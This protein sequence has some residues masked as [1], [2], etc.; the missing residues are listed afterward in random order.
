VRAELAIVG[1]GIIGAWAAYLARARR[2]S[3][4]IVVVDRAHPGRGAT[5]HSAGV[6]HRTMGSTPEVRAFAA[7]SAA[8]HAAAAREI[9][10]AAFIDVPGYWAIEPERLAGLSSALG[11]APAAASAAQREELL[12][13]LPGLRLDDGLALHV[14]G[15]CGRVRPPELAT[16]LLAASVGPGGGGDRLGVVRGEVARMAREGERW[17]LEVD[18]V[19]RVDAARVLVA[20]GPWVDLGGWPAA[21][22]AAGIRVKKV[23]ALELDGAPA[24]APLVVF[25]A[26]DAF[27][28]PSPTAGRWVFSYRCSTWLDAP[29]PT[30]AVPFGDDERREALAALEAIAP[31]LVA[32]VVHIRVSADAYAA[33]GVPLVA[34][35]DGRALVTACGGSG[36]R[37]AP[38]LAERAL[39]LLDG[40]SGA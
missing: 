8:L 34:A 40:T 11:R 37:L 28:A 27:L 22:Q 29:P 24:D 1:G 36:V 6:V 16:A 4:S 38:A 2:P 23:A 5:F 20:P 17:H 26:R 39:D 33:G 31:A 15:D 13:A 18:G 12:R 32:S 35:A 7:R 30:G 9:A 3:S 19:G 21:V 25:P 10:A 14:D